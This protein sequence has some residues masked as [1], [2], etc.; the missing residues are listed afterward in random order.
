VKS[1]SAGDRNPLALIAKTFAVA[2]LVALFC[3]ISI[4]FTR[5]LGGTSTLWIASGILAGIL[6]TSHRRLWP[7]Y[8]IAALGY[9]TIYRATVLLSL[10]QLGMESL[11]LSGLSGLER[12]KATG[13]PS[14]AIGEGLADALN[15][16]GY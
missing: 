4:R 1:D 7:G 14:S 11:Q 15:V 16:G 13:R 9:S 3:W 10:W 12:V 2:V 5:E 8:V 6:L